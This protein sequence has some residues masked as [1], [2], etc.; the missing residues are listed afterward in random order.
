[1]GKPV[2]AVSRISVEII[3]EWLSTGA[4]VDKIYH[5]GGNKVCS[6][7]FEERDFA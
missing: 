7:V 5:E 1:M 3:L 2:I 6:S 4:T